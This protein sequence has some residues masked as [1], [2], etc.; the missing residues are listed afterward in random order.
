MFSSFFL[1]IKFADLANSSTY[2]LPLNDPFSGIEDEKLVLV[3]E[4]GEVDVEEGVD[5]AEMSLGPA[6]LSGEEEAGPS[7][8]LV[9]PN[10]SLHYLDTLAQHGSTGEYYSLMLKSTKCFLCHILF[11]IEY[12]PQS[13]PSIPCCRCPRSPQQPRVRAPRAARPG[14]PRGGRH[15]RRG[16]LP[17]PALAQRLPHRARRGRGRH[18]LGRLELRLLMIDL[19]LN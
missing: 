10:T 3:T 18:L 15:P 1:T 13:N 14:E 9:T 19:V 2:D 5:A 17:A 16:Q 8:T 7:A 6:E 12:I 11:T 4:T